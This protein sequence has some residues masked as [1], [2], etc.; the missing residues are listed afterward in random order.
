MTS[1][2]AQMILLDINSRK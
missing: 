2:T 1:T